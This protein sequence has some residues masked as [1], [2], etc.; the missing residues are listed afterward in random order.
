MKKINDIIACKAL[1][2]IMA[3]S[4]G[5]WTIRIPTI[6]DQIQTDYLGIGY[7]MATFAIG[8]IIMMLCANYFISKSSSK[9]IIIYIVIAQ[10]LL[11][12]P[13]PFIKDLVT[14]MI[15]AFMFG[16][17][18]GLFE[19]CINLKASKIESREGKSMMSGFHAFWSIGLLSGSLLTS[20][21]LEYK[22]SFFTNSLIFI[23]MISPI[24]YFSSLTIKN[25]QSDTL[26]FL[27]IFFKWPLFLIILFLLAITAVFLEGGTDS[28]GSL[29]MRDYILAEGFNIGLAAIAFNG[30]MVLGRLIG[31]RLKEIFGIYNFLV[32]SVI[33]SFVGSIFIASS[34]SL[35]FAIIGFVIAGFCVSSIIPICYTF[36]ASIKNLNPTVGIT[37]ITIGTYGVFMIAPPTL[38]YVADIFGIE[39]V[40]TPMLILFL[41]IS[42]IVIFQKKLFKN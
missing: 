39:Y 18:F 14:F 35:L 17:C 1:F 15:L 33:G 20:L 34:S 28:W 12:L 3:F 4:I 24:L 36:G 42:I 38:G 6:R 5:L 25:I 2:F 26:S 22:I 32:F 21:F 37:I 41:L 19:I 10:W 31:D 9:K 30:S 13:V 11:W 23:I 16:F 27:S 40:Y 8:S 29:Y 7:I